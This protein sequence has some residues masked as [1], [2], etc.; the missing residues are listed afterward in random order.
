MKIR[1]TFIKT[2]HGDRRILANGNDVGVIKPLRDGYEVIGTRY[3]ERWPVDR[4]N[5]LT[6]KQAKDVARNAWQQ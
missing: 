6:L 2:E 3:Y 5:P 4:F 1:V